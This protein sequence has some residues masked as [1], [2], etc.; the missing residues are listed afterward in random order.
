MSS[1]TRAN[2]VLLA[3]LVVQAIV[4]V[5]L[6]GEDAGQAAPRDDAGVAGRQPF[7]AIDSKEVRAL[8]LTSGDGKVLRLEGATPKEGEAVTWSV[9]SRD[10]FPARTADVEK[11]VEAA[12]KVRFVRVITRQEKRYAKL[13]VADGVMHARV[14]V[15][16]AGGRKLADFR[17]GES[18]DFSSVHVRLEGDP[19]VY[20]AK[21]VSTWEFPVSVSGL[22]DTAF[23]DLPADQVVRVRLAAGSEAFEILKEVPESRPDSRPV[24]TRGVDTGPAT[25]AAETR[26]EARWV[27]AADPATALDKTK[28][29]SWIR[30]LA[31][32]NLSEPIG[33]TAK[34]EYGFDKPT[35]KATLVFA[36]GKEVTI[37]IGAERKDERDSYMTATG[38]DFVVTA[39]SWNVTDQFQKK[40]KDLA[41]GGTPAPD[42]D[43]DEDR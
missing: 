25:R 3:V 11:I 20:E 29:E 30:G 42:H 14:Q 43:H 26:P 39:S 24:E 17:I 40:L 12:K 27:A 35:S 4:I 28:V 19:A 41:A 22:V 37:T 38:K 32:I 10:G 13:S 18:K 23:L 34:P 5:A 16:A 9:A 33:K 8:T 6:P 7:A 15:E 31:R 21:D 2:L 36:D 1:L